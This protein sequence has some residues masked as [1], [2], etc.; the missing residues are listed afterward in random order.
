MLACKPGLGQVCMQV[1]VYKRELGRVCKLGLGRVY[2][3]V[4]ACRLAQGLVR[5]Q[6][7]VCKQALGQDGGGLDGQAWP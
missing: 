4:L 6:E 1:Q 7:Q 3:Q 5:K 2:M